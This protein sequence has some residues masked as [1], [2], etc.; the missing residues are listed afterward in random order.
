MRKEKKDL[1]VKHVAYHMLLC[2]N[3]CNTCPSSSVLRR[4]ITV[5]PN[6]FWHEWVKTC[7]ALV[8]DKQSSRGDY[9]SIGSGGSAPH[10]LKKSATTCDCL[11]TCPQQA[12]ESHLLLLIPVFSHFAGFT[13]QTFLK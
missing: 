2:V 13:M 12:A 6:T 3:V 10:A 7:E 8:Y 1:V 5:L 11:P 9:S 4:A